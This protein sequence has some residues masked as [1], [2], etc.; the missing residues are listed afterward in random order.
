M[1]DPRERAIYDYDHF[2]EEDP[3]KGTHEVPFS[4]DDDMGRGT[5]Y[6]FS[7]TLEELYTGKTKNIKIT[8]EIADAK[9]WVVCLLLQLPAAS[10]FL[11]VS[12]ANANIC[13]A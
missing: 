10:L 5:E 2:G 8:R 12:N 9:G 3:K 7:C 11:F 6:K 4:A 13:C 1:S